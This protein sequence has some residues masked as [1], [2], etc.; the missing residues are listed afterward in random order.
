M[1][2]DVILCHQGCLGG[3][4]MRRACATVVV[5][6]IANLCLFAAA[7]AQ[8]EQSRSLGALRPVTQQPSRLLAATPTQRLL[9][10]SAKARP[11]ALQLRAALAR[12]PRGRVDISAIDKSAVPVLLSARPQFVQNLRVY[13]AAD[14][15][16]AATEEN[17]TAIEINGTR[18]AAMAPQRFRL[19]PSIPSIPLQH[20]SL[21]APPPTPAQP[22]AA[23]ARSRFARVAT[24]QMLRVRPSSSQ[25][26]AAADALQNVRVDQTSSGAD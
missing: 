15:F 13:A 24:P 12:L 5:A 1:N 9:L 6:A 26:A 20:A 17:G 3:Y 2:L 4:T 14:R 23:A 10:T 22:A 18:V 7:Y 11:Q 16:T 8:P 25:T 21:E 19:P